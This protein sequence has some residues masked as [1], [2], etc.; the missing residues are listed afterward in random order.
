MS[1]GSSERCT[2]V[3]RVCTR[4]CACVRACVRAGGRAGGGTE[5]QD[6]AHGDTATQQGVQHFAQRDDTRGR[7]ELLHL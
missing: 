7:F 1:T 5:F 2:L 4:A 3:M 6:L